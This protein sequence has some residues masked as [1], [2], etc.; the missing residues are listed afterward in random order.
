[1]SMAD[2]TWDDL[3]S[4]IHARI[5]AATAHASIRVIHHRPDVDPQC[6][7][8]IWDVDAVAGDRFVHMILGLREDGSVAEETQTFL[9]TEIDD[10]TFSPEGDA[11]VAIRGPAGRQS[12]LIPAS[13]GQVLDRPAEARRRG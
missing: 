5:M 12:I 8:G 1:M 10:V 2:R 4:E 7:G 13:I 3:P 6:P 9:T 11:A